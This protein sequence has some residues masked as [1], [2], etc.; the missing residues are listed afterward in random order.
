MTRRFRALLLVLATLPLASGCAGLMPH[1]DP[2]PVVRGPFHTRNQQPIALT[3]MAFRPRRPVTQPV[4]EWAGA[5]QV[6]WSDMEEI[7]RF[8]DPSPQESVTFD[9]ETVR[10]TLRGRYGLS[11]NLDVE[12]ELPFLWAGAGGMDHFIEQYHEFFGLP[13]GA[14][15]DYPD[16][17]FEMR[18]I[19]NGEVLYE[20]DGNEMRIQDVPIFLT[21]QLLDEEPGQPAVA[22]RAG[23]ELPIGSQSKGFGNG[24]FDFG[25][26]L[27]AEKSYGRWTVSGGF[28]WVFPGQSRR[29]K[30]AEGDHHYDPMLALQLSGELRWQHDLSIIVGTVWTSRMLHSVAHEEVNREVF[31]LGWGVAWDSSENSRLQVSMH[32]DLV[33]ATG[34]DLA[35]HVGWTW[36]Y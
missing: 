21:W 22:A 24:A 31:D 2:E 8:Q 17:Q 14:R 30:D 23:L 25:A 10:T 32:E 4:G 26:G 12:V 36:G 5:V 7:R 18:V 19:S 6:A 3:L 11:E 34:S 1:D 15:D 9:G 16:D 20:L 13:D 35:V 29:M 27:I 28:D 33:A